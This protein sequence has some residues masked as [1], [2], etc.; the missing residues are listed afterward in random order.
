MKTAVNKILKGKE[1]SFNNRFGQMC[2]HYLFDPVACSPAA[3]WETPTVLY[4]SAQGQGLYRTQP[5]AFEPVHWLG[6]NTQAS[7]DNRQDRVAGL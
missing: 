4:P 5:M 7:D 6:K 2:S 3:G 1:R